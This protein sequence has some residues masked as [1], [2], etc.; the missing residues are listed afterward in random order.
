M[1]KRKIKLVEELLYSSSPLSIR[2]LTNEFSVS[3]RIIKYDI[4]KI[5]KEIEEIGAELLNKKGT[6]YYFSPDAKPRLIKYYGL[7]DAV[8]SKILCK[9]PM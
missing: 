3:E 2:Y 1:A 9:F 5:R 4:S 8:K 7:S 6:G